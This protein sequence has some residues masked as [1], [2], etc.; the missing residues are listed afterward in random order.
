MDQILTALP[1]LLACAGVF[2]L[3]GIVKGVLSLGLPLVGL[4]LLMLVVDV[5]TAVALLMVPLVMSNLLQA[6]EGE[7]AMPL[8]R[9]FWPLLLCLAIGTLIGTALL[10]ALDQRILLLAIGSFA[11]IFATASM[12]RPHFAIPPSIELWLGPTLG[13]VSGVIGGMSTLFGPILAI[14]VVGLRLP[15][16]TFVKVISLFYLTAASFLLLGGSSQG[17]AGWRELVLSALSMIPVYLGM[18]IG[19]RIRRYIDPEKFQMLVLGVV[20]LTGANM[21]RVGLGY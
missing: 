2:A 19:Q 10:A 5:K 3:A 11:I 17:A 15:R 20:W 14:Y 7:P 9:R 6:I 12:L 21:I 1:T 8:L 4:P 13:F 16:D 18:L